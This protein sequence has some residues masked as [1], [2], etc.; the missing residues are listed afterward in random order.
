MLIIYVFAVPASNYLYRPGGNS[1]PGRPSSLCWIVHNA[2]AW[3]IETAMYCVA[4]A[5][6]YSLFLYL[7]VVPSPSCSKKGS[8]G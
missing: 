7:I 6:N 2:S 8:F 3:W 5:R 4:Q 1:R